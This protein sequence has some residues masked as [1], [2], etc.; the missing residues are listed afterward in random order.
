MHRAEQA[1]RELTCGTDVA[2]S[3]LA[4]SLAPQSHRA[5]DAALR[6]NSGSNAG[7]PV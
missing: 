7:L 3:G 6:D 4:R 5:S 2:H 1:T